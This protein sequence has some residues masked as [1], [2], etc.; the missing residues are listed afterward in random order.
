MKVVS[1]TTPLNYLVWI[2][3]VDII[4]KLFNTLTIPPAVY[5]ELQ[6]PDTPDIVQDWANRLPS[7]V[8]VQPTLISN[9]SFSSWLDPGETEAIIL[10]QEIQADLILLDDLRARKIAQNQGLM[11][12]GTL[13]LLDRATSNNLLDLPLVIQN[14][15]R[16][17]FWVSDRLLQQLL[18]KH[19]FYSTNTTQY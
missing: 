12:T 2:G 11:V 10:A 18:Q 13:G 15:K 16:T 8:I 19:S 17:S 3:E 4:P 5:Q 14:L 6:H 9:A 7:W 1:N